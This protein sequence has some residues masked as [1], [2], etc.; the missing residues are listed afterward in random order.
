MYKQHHGLTI[1]GTKSVFLSKANPIF[2]H[3]HQQLSAIYVSQHFYNS[4]NSSFPCRLLLIKAN[5]IQT[6]IAMDVS[7]LLWNF[8]YRIFNCNSTEDLMIKH[9]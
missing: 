1:N 7:Y 8:M 9:P 2:P 5:V 6:H 3:M 4:K